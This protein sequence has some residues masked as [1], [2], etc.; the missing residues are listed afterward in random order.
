MLAEIVGA[1]DHFAA[2]KIVRLD[3]RPIW[4]HNCVTDNG[5]WILDVHG[6]RINDPVG[7]ERTLNQVAGVVTVGLFAQRSADIV[8]VGNQRIE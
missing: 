2:R 3:G 5:N 7:L 4:R 1:P 8:L 6:W